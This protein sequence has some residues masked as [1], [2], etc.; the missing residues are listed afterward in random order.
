[1][2]KFEPEEEKRIAQASD[3]Y[4]RNPYVK[5]SVIARKFRVKLR[6]WKA[7]LAG[8][9]AQNTKGGHN[10][11]L[12]HDQEEGLKQYIDFLVYL[13]HRADL[14]AVRATVNKI[15]THSGSTR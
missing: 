5:K 10:K 7:R 15:L 14:K 3:F 11:A 6:L 2:A 13:G 12:S 9:I 4:A 8:R 1:M